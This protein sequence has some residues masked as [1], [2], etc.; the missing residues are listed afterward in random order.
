M[1]KLSEYR[2]LGRVHVM[3]DF[4]RDDLAK[5]LEPL[6]L[7]TGAAAPPSTVPSRPAT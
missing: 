6:E 5:M 2:R 4:R 7:V 3:I 1:D